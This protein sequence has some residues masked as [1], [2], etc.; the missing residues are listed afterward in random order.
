MK[1]YSRIYRR[2]TGITVILLLAAQYFSTAPAAAADNVPQPAPERLRVEAIYDQPPNVQP[3]IG[4]NEFDR[5]YADL[6]SD[7]IT[8]PQDIPSPS[9]YLNYYLQ[10]VTKPYRPAKPTF[11]KEGNVRAETAADN[12]IRLKEL[13]SG[14]VY[15]A[16]SRAYYTYATETG[17][18]T[19]PEST[20]SNTVKFLTDIEIEAFP[21]G[22]N[23]IKIVWDDVWNSGKRMDYKLYVSENSSF[24]NTPPIYIGQEQISQ[25]G[26][27]TVNESAG[28]LEY[29]HTVR[30]PGRVYY[31]KIEPD[32]AE[33]ELKRSP[34]SRVVAVS[35][36]ILARTIKMSV[37]PVTGNT[38]WKLEWSPVVTG[39]SGSD[40]KITYQIYRG[41]GTAGSIEQY[42]ASKD[43]TTFFLTVAPG[44]ENYYY[45]IKALVTRNGQDVYPG[46][47]ITSSEIYVRESEVAAKPAVPE[48]VTE[49]SDASMV[50]RQEINA[51]DATILWRAPRKGSGEADSEVLYDIWLVTDPNLINDPPASS[52]IASD[53]KMNQG[54]F[55]MSGNIL[56]G[57]KYTV[58]DLIP[59][60]A[61]YLKI[62]AKKNYVEYVDNMLQN[63]TLESDPALKIFITPAPGP[64]DQPVVPGTPPFRLKTDRQGKEMVTSSTVVITLKNK[65]YEQYT[66]RKKPDADPGELSWYFRT[67]SQLDETGLTLI[68]PIDDLADKL[69]AGD[70]GIDPMKFRKVEYDEGVT[71]DV[72]IV[73]YVPGMDYNALEN[74]PADKV[75]GHTVTPNDP[76]E[77]ISADDNVRDGQRH[78]VDITLYDLEPNKTYVIWVRAVRRSVNLM[79]GP[80]DPIIVTTLPDLPVEAEKPT[81]PVFNYHHEGDTYIDLGWDFNREYVYYLEYGT[82]DDRSKAVNRLTITPQE[83]EYA[84]Y[85]RVSGLTPDTVYYFWIQAEATSAAGEKKQSDFSDS[86]IVKTVKEIPPDTPLGFGAKNRTINSITYEWL[87]VEGMEYILEIDDGID[88]VGS[89]RHHISNASEF[90]VTGLRSNFRYYARLYAFDPAKGLESAPTQ[91]VVVRT[92]RS[93]DDYDSDQDTEYVIEGDFIIKDGYAVNGTWTVRITGVNADRFIRHVQTDNVLDYSIDLKT[94]PQGTKT[95]SLVISQKVFK[96]LGTLG[97]NLI[98]RTVSNAIIIRPGVMADK[99]GIYGTPAGESEFII[100]ITL[101]ADVTGDTGNMTFKTPVSAIA[102]NL[103]D[104]LSKKIDSFGR[105]LKVE[106]EYTSAG[107]YVPDTTFGYYLPAGKSTWNKVSVQRNYDYDAGIGTLAFEMPVP[108]KMAIA[109]QGADF[110]TDISRSYARRAIANVASVHELKSVTG[111]RFEPEK[112]LTVGA[113]V[114]FMLDVLD[115]DYGINY[116]TLAAR[117]GIINAADTGRADE[118]CTREQLISMAAKVCE[119]KTGEKIGA[120]QADL[121]VYRDIDEANPAL[122]PRIR[123][124]HR[125]GVIISRFSDMLGP[126]DIV[127]RADAMVLLEKL[128]RWAGEL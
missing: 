46:I 99:N 19:S 120:D 89:T 100:D 27:V 41:T 23:Q 127:T 38:I 32:T 69:E 5:Y 90:T 39:L 75:I 3:A 121:S 45:V 9:I 76:D 125:T 31:I 101:Q 72:G 40:I 98:L 68:P 87:A 94:M 73:E 64:T 60:T 124:A 74:I 24:A 66:D 78:N 34:S 37:D 91:S 35:S 106:Y 10:E 47:Q 123:Y 97:E 103:S 15:Y 119:I 92:L 80:S 112:D 51:T 1:P 81:V 50:V 65:W 13:N 26:P 14:T 59:N 29:I 28:K 93:G 43:D 118:K 16:Y 85:Y 83:L 70:A 30:D 20:P 11:L 115:E 57:Y 62:V 17:T 4:Y 42:M 102:V 36:Y 96:A 53:L 113:A 128:L 122:L 82:V 55:I 48:L 33:T 2:I 7:R 84:T 111:K 49:L 52:K 18:Y 71:I 116:M 61:Y 56:L 6:K 21:Y 79:S 105:P 12:E 25:T 107:W 63:V 117:A 58:R 8:R 108:G 88:Y 86:Y 109:D 110:Y 54:N 67:P 114:K 44:E 104:G 126:K 95:I 77:D 22:P